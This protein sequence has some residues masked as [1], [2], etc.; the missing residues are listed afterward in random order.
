VIAV[1][2]VGAVG[3]IEMDLDQLVLVRDAC[4]PF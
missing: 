3:E 2:D 4:P 1:V